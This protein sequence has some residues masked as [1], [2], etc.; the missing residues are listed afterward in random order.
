MHFQTARRVKTGRQ[1]P[2]KSQPTDHL[3]AG[4]KQVF[5][6]GSVRWITA[7]KVFFFHS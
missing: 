6:C 3:P 4:G 7:Q 5:A 1:L 2:V